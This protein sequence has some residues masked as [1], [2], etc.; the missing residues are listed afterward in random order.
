MNIVRCILKEG[1][2]VGRLDG[3]DIWLRRFVYP[4]DNICVEIGQRADENFIF[5]LQKRLSSPSV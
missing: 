3:K 2:A 5:S 1:K 4:R